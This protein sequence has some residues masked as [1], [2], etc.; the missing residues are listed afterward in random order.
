MPGKYPKGY[1]SYFPGTPVSQEVTQIPF[2]D[3]ITPAVKNSSYAHYSRKAALSE[4]PRTRPFIVGEENKMLPLV[5]YEILHGI[6][7]PSPVFLHAPVGSGKSHFAEGLFLVWKSR[8][9][10][11][12]GEFLSVSDFHSRLGEAMRTQ[13]MPEF[14]RVFYHLDFLVLEDFQ[15]IA[16]HAFAQQEMI[17]VFDKLRG[18]ARILITASQ[19]LGHLS[20]EAKLVSR[21]ME[22]ISVRIHPPLAEARQAILKLPEYQNLAPLTDDARDALAEHTLQAGSTV[23]E[24]LAVLRQL[25]MNRRSEKRR[26][27]TSVDV[28]AHYQKKR[29]ENSLKIADIAKVAGKYYN[30]RL[31]DLR[32]KSRRAT[33]VIARDVI[34]YLTR[35]MTDFTLAEIGAYFSG[36]DHT[37]IH[38]GVKYV[39]TQLKTDPELR[40]VVES[41]TADLKP[42]GELPAREEK[43]KSSKNR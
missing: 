30:V 43:K 6:E 8:H 34:Y 21:I 25:E 39:E 19:P 4:S 32:S 31:N 42:L 38:H 9:P 13:T 26:K 33:L 37:T 18:R 1:I 12:K 7:T 11:A 3:G 27:I 29:E 10:A 14:Q 16:A 20:L 23:S 22:G 28:L 41:L 36:R 24:M 17:H 35:K 5:A 40:H 2:F 15:Q